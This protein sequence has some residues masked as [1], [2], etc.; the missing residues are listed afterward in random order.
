MEKRDCGK[1]K[2]GKLLV[3]CKGPG[4][5]WNSTICQLGLIVWFLDRVGIASSTSPSCFRPPD[6][7]APACIS[8]VVWRKAQVCKCS[9]PLFPSLFLFCFE[10]YVSQAEP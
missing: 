8:C 10:V 5:E 7:W 9:M 4:R 1:S 6:C 2:E 3:G